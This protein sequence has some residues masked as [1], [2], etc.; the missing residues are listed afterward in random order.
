MH[1]KKKKV[2]SWSQEYMKVCKPLKITLQYPSN[3]NGRVGNTNIRGG[4]DED[5]QGASRHW[6]LKI[7]ERVWLEECSEIFD[8][9]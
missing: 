3:K 1:S 8:H 5:M 7:T 6:K 2:K 4:L 9:S